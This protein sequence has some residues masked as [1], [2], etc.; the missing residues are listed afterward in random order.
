M[1]TEETRQEAYIR[2]YGRCENPLCAKHLMGNFHAHHIYWRSRYKGQDRDDL[3]NVATLCYPCHSSIHDQAN[4]ILDNYLIAIADNRKQP[5]LRDR[6]KHKDF[7][8]Q[9]TKRARERKRKIAAFKDNHQG[10]S[11][12]QVQYRQRKEYYANLQMPKRT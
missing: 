12:T 10:L 8:T 11:P 9:K 1:I 5:H 3:W 7:S 2:S 4:I 6:R